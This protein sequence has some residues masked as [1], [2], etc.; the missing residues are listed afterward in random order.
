MP[1]SAGVYLVPAF[2]GLG[3]PHWDPYA[4]GI[5]VGLSR[6]VTKAHVVRAALEGIAYQV[7]DVIEAMRSEMR[8]HRG[9]QRPC[10]GPLLRV[11]GGASANG[12][13][14]QFQADI[15]QVQIQR[16]KSVE[17]TG[18]GAAF[19]A[20]LGCGLLSSVDELAGLV[21]PAQ[22]FQ[23][24]MDQNTRRLLLSGWE[25]AVGRAKG[26]QPAAS[27]SDTA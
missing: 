4:R 24:S 10:D 14:M 12:F 26:W 19:M 15:S 2:T 20:G 11:D 22:T 21:E 27:N 13:L 1:D 7:N 23:P 5:L 6:G 8:S 17:L 3:A 9:G 18:I 25:R 16:N